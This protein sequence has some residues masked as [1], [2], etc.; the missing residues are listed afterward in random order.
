MELG[1]E[2]MVKRDPRKRPRASD[3]TAP[4]ASARRRND[5]PSAPGSAGAD[6]ERDDAAS[7]G[8]VEAPERLPSGFQTS[9]EPA[10]W[11]QAVPLPERSMAAPDPADLGWTTEDPL[12]RH[13]GAEADRLGAGF[14]P[15]DVGDETGDAT[16]PRPDANVAEEI[17]AETG[18]TFQ[19]TEPIG[20]TEKVAERDRRRWELDPASSE[21]YELRT[22]TE[23]E[24]EVEGESEHGGRGTEAPR[25]G[26]AGA[27]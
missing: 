12:D 20:V 25:K 27:A 8:S 14:H 18:V 19:D 5:D 17:G 26:P 13:P 1:K 9:P 16:S 7:A 3:A 21:D 4:R 10:P 11:V 6:A 24:P 15:K 23:P 22:Q 2:T